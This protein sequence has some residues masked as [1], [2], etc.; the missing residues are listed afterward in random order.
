MTVA[1]E[2]RLTLAEYLSYEDSTGQRFEI[3]D[4]VLV[5]M[6]T[7][8]AHNLSIAFVLG[9]AFANAGIPGYLIGSK[10]RMTVSSSQ[11]SAREPDLMVHSPA[12]YA[13]VSQKKESLLEYFDPLPL[14]LVEI[15]SP[16]EEGSSNF[17]RDYVEKPVE[18]AD[19][20][21]PEFWI[22]DPVRSWVRVLT[23]QGN[24]YHQ[25]EFRGDEPIVSSAL[26]DLKITAARVL[27]A[28]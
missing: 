21:I 12:S 27:A 20:G 25:Q 22:V 3:L 17:D 1:T 19:R 18:Y 5:L 9:M 11:V 6:G 8:S 7:E 28:R 15:V 26:P 16:V 4:G 10:H 23:L 2:R 14:L 24:T 13:A